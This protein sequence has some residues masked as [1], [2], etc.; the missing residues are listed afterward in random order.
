[1]F[2]FSR[3]TCHSVVASMPAKR[4]SL[5]RVGQILFSSK[6]LA[7]KL[8]HLKF[9]HVPGGDTHYCSE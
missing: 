1:M 6:A 2:F 5:E 7:Y 3:R 9:Y 8:Q 4:F